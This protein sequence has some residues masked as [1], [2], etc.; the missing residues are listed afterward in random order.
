MSLIL[1]FYGKRPQGAPIGER[2]IPA[3]VEQFLGYLYT[4]DYNDAKVPASRDPFFEQPPPV[5]DAG[6]GNSHGWTRRTT[7][8]EEARNDYLATA[9]DPQVARRHRLI[10]SMGVYTMAGMCHIPDSRAIQ[11]RSVRRFL[12]PR[13]LP[14]HARA[15]RS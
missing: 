12:T 13:G 5:T 7:R 10:I 3:V 2:R 14:S 1:H 15:H 9:N 4:L 6:S 8:S 11:V